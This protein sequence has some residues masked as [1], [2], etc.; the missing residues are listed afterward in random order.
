MSNHPA[1]LPLRRVTV[2]LFAED[3]KYVERKSPGQLSDMLR[4]MLHAHL[5]KAKARK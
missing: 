1:R 3:V 5:A 4:E 2:N